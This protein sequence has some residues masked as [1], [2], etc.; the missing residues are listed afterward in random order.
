LVFSCP[1]LGKNV[2][3]MNC[4]CIDELYDLTAEREQTKK[5]LYIS[6]QFIHAYTWTIARDQQRNWSSIYIVS[7]F[8][9]NDCIWRIPISEIQ[10]L[11]KTASLD[12][13]HSIRGRFV[14]GDYKYV[15]N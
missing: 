14:D 9:R 6:N 1:R 13:P 15:T 10:K 11:F 8:D 2:H 4:H 12:Y 5:P 3:R 7:E